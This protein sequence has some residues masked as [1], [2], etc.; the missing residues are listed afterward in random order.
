MEGKQITSAVSYLMGRCS[1]FPVR[2]LG[3]AEW[4]ETA[5]IWQVDGELRKWSRI[6]SQL[7]YS[8]SWEGSTREN[9]PHPSIHPD[10]G[11]ESGT[12]SLS[13]DSSHIAT[14]STWGLRLLFPAVILRL[15][16]LLTVLPTPTHPWSFNPALVAI[17]LM[18]SELWIPLPMRTVSSTHLRYPEQRGILYSGTHVLQ[19]KWLEAGSVPFFPLPV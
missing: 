14:V 9:H 4:W 5:H 16:T 12:H 10:T 11:S 3:P 13:D 8:T 15:A 2:P 18:V 6:H 19:N 1:V 17:Q 7:P